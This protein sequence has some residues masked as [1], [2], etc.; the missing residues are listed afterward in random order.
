MNI[1][2]FNK[3]SSLRKLYIPLAIEAIKQEFLKVL[4]DRVKLTH[5]WLASQLGI[6]NGLAFPLLVQVARMTKY[7][8]STPS[9]VVLW[10]DYILTEEEKIKY[11]TPRSIANLR[12]LDIIADDSVMQ[13]FKKHKVVIHN[14]YGYVDIQVGCKIQVSGNHLRISTTKNKF[15]HILSLVE[16]IWVNRSDN[17]GYRYT[18]T[19]NWRNK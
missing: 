14:D 5:V 18:T 11:N 12:I 1:S 7:C 8:V 17:T 16:G 9:G 13:L 19:T 2:Q 15:A 6:S 3:S 4:K 10:S